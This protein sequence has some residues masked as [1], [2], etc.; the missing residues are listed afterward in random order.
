MRVS[1]KVTSKHGGIFKGAR[2]VAR[3]RIASVFSLE[4][5][6]SG[7]SR[8]YETVHM[9]EKQNIRE[10]EREKETLCSVLIEREE[11]HARATSERK[12]ERQNDTSVR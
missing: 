1:P 11:V 4:E 3:V 10:R 5:L 7:R 9:F 8:I 6:V 12:M 2:N